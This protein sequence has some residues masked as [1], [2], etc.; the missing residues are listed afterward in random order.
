M[1]LSFRIFAA[2]HGD[3]W[4]WQ[5]PENEGGS[6]ELASKQEGPWRHFLTLSNE[7][8]HPRLLWC[9]MDPEKRPAT[10]FGASATNRDATV[11]S[12]NGNISYFLALT[13]TN[14][15]QS[16]EQADDILAG[17]RNVTLDGQP[18][19]AGEAILRGGHLIG[20]QANTL[21]RGLGQLLKADGTVWQQRTRLLNPPATVTNR[22]LVP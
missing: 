4:P 21:H 9:P 10:A 18:V 8:N 16:G 12:G 15:N 7:L 17:D 1:G 22:L 20:F 13:P 14:R 5:V 19:S 3:K 6:L 11:F 2:D